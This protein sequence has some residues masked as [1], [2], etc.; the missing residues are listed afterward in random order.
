MRKPF[1]H[2]AILSTSLT[3]PNLP[4][5][6][7]PPSA[8]K[9]SITKPS[10]HK[11][12]CGWKGTASYLDIVTPDVEISNAIWYYPEPKPAVNNIKGYYAFYGSKVD[13]KEEDE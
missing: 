8:L 11:T 2:A 3:D 12:V 7:F 6:Y 10:S 13:I 1:T 4:Q 5:P 9:E